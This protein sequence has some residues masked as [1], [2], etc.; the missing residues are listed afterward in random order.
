MSSNLPTYEEAIQSQGDI[1][2][3][4]NRLDRGITNPAFEAT[5]VQPTPTNHVYVIQ[6]QSGRPSFQA[7]V[8]QQVFCVQCRGML[9]NKEAI[10]AT[11]LLSYGQINQKTEIFC[12][13]FQKRNQIE[14]LIFLGSFGLLGRF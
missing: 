7:Q 1:L 10:R 6:Q 3:D 9:N 5:I 14:K 8:P 11:F 2:I 12:G 4:V 13:R